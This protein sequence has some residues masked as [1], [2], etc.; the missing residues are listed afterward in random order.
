M[1]HRPDAAEVRHRQDGAAVP[2]LHQRLRGPRAGDER[3]GGD[4]D[5]H[6]EAIARRVDE[7]AFQILRGS[8]RDGVDEHVE[9]PAECLPGLVEDT[10]DVRVGA[11]VALRHE[12]RADRVGELA[13]ALLD[14]LALEG[15]GELGALVV[16]PLGD[17]PCDGALVRDPQDQRLLPSNLPAM[18]R[19]YWD[20][21]GVATVG[22]VPA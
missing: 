3:V 16:Q 21:P 10:R 8:E 7:P 12:L 14:P 5:G 9:S 11:Y 1:R 19:S 20:V 15:E 22:A 13:D 18:R 17:R 6:P 4:V 2:G